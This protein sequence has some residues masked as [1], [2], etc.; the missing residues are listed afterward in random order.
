M[1]YLSRVIAEIISLP[2][3]ERQVASIMHENERV[4]ME[5]FIAAAADHPLIQD[6]GG[7]RKARWA[8]PGAGKSGGLRVNGFDIPEGPEREPVCGRSRHPGPPRGANKE[9]GRDKAGT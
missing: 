8:L 5:F 3:Y 2:G 7:F 4:V 1:P 9:G 6:G